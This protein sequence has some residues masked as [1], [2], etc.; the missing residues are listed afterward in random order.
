MASRD[1]KRLEIFK[2]RLEYFRNIL[3][4]LDAWTDAEL[5]NL[6]PWSDQF[7]NVDE[8]E[9]YFENATELPK[10]VTGKKRKQASSSAKPTRRPPASVS[11]GSEF[12]R[13]TIR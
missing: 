13:S 9:R 12:G 8:Y 3:S 11:F 4:A 10:L 5:A 6:K 7:V 1:A 2:K